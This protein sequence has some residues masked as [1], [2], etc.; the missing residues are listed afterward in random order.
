MTNKKTF[1]ALILAA[2]MCVP[3]SLSA[4][5]TIGSGRAPSEWSLLDLCTDYQQKGLHNAR[6]NT[7]ERNLLFPYYEP[8]VPAMGLM[9]FNTNA[10]PIGNGEYIGC[11]EFW[12]GVQWISLCESILPPPPPPPFLSVTPGAWVFAH[13]LDSYH[14]FTVSTNLTGDIS[15][16]NLPDWA[17]SV[18]INQAAR[19]FTIT[20]TQANTGAN[21]RPNAVVTVTVGGMTETVT[22]SQHGTDASGTVIN[23]GAFVGAF[24]RNNQRGERLIRMPSHPF[25]PQNAPWFAFATE[26]WIQLDTHVTVDI[27]GEPTRIRTIG[28]GT[29][30]MDFFGNE[31]EVLAENHRLPDGT[32]DIYVRIPNNIDNPTSWTI[33]QRSGVARAGGQVNGEGNIVFR[34]GLDSYNPNPV[35]ANSVHRTPQN[36]DGR[37]PRYGQVIV[38]HNRGVH[39]IWVRQGEDTDYLMRVGDAGG[40]NALR[41]T[42]NA[43]RIRTFSPFNLTAYVLD[44]QVGTRAQQ[45]NAGWIPPAG[46]TRS[47]FTDYPSQTGAFFQWASATT[48]SMRRAWNPISNANYSTTNAYGNWYTDATTPY[49]A[50]DNE[51]CPPGFRRPQDGPNFGD[52][53]LANNTQEMVQASE[54]RQSL[55]LNPQTGRVNNEANRVVGFYADGFFDRRPITNTDDVNGIVKAAIVAAGTVDIALR[56]TLFFNAESGASL[57]FPHSGVID[58]WRLILVGYTGSYWS[59]TQ[60]NARTAWRLRFTYSPLSG[61]NSR[62]DSSTN[63]ILAA[64]IRCVAE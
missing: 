37:A 51:T 29:D 5:I 50:T 38:V 55:F 41:T 17:A 45:A 53:A 43:H 35:V 21:P 31:T 12:N 44:A 4:Q 22:I 39:I 13:T 20:T 49:L 25:S 14:T 15:V 47:R 9:I 10:M 33:E 7:T 60:H 62:L 59:S 19:T 28:A 46:Q 3:M 11:L 48:S 63:R 6:M 54:M 58:L 2:M 34:I 8:N 1:F 61:Y 56:G 30:N 40:V 32:N 27:N 52:V 36:T 26:D 23:A 57:F 16:T 64:P 24:W 42:E 18:T